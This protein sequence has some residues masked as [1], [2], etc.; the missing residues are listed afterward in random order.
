MKFGLTNVGGDFYKIIEVS[1][2]EGLINLMKQHK[3]PLILSPNICYK[4]PPIK[5]MPK[6]YNDCRYELE[7]Y[8][9]YRE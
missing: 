3:H 6:E 1:T 8:D 9:N 4:D 2:I 5:G 7:V